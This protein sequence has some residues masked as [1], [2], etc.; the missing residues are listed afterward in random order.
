MGRS[1]AR[2]YLEIRLDR[3]RHLRRF[4]SAMDRIAQLGQVRKGRQGAD[5]F[6]HATLVLLQEAHLRR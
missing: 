1:P 2:Y 5:A 6:H 3:A 4:L